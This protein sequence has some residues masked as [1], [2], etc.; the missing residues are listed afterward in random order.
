MDTQGARETD[1]EKDNEETDSEGGTQAKTRGDRA[2]P[3]E[4]RRCDRKSQRGPEIPR[5]PETRGSGGQRAEGPG[6]AATGSGREKHGGGGARQAR[7]RGWGRRGPGTRAEWDRNKKTGRQALGEDRDAD[8]RETNTEGRGQEARDGRDGRG[9][10]GRRADVRGSPGEGRP[11]RRRGARSTAGTDSRWGA[12][13]RP[14]Q[15]LTL[16]V[17]LHHQAGVALP[18]PPGQF[19]QGVLVARQQLLLRGL[20]EA[21]GRLPGWGSGSR[22]PGVQGCGGRGAGWGAAEAAAPRQRGSHPLRPRGRPASPR[23]SRFSTTAA[24]S[25]RWSLRSRKRCSWSRCAICRRRSCTSV[26]CW[27]ASCS[28]LSRSRPVLLFASSLGEGEGSPGQGDW[29]AGDSLEPRDGRG[30]PEVGDCVEQGSQ[31]PGKGQNLADVILTSQ[32]AES[33]LG[34]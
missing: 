33:F 5:G 31:D 4:R 6:D 8:Q 13:L 32:K 25:C 29:R 7:A 19:D 21:P 34:S 18:G 10:R 9:V 20:P 30:Q 11:G 3:G 26:R 24:S 22:G 23:F 17:L 27:A 14:R 2:G 28:A 15:V 16:Q 12:P 1:A